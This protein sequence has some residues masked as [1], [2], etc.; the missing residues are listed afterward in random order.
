[1]TF[2]MNW[3]RCYYT[4]ADSADFPTPLTSAVMAVGYL[5]TFMTAEDGGVFI[6]AHGSWHNQSNQYIH[7]RVV[8]VP[9]NGDTPVT[10]PDWNDPT[11]QWGN[12]DFVGGFGNGPNYVARPSGIAVG[13]QGTLFVADD[14]NG[15]VYRIRPN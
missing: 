9:M 6:T 4:A 7:P 10:A 13:S 5:D 15:L 1:M 8:Y 11:V 2:A 12:M 14:A 3:Y